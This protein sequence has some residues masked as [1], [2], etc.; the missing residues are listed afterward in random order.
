MGVSPLW[1]VFGKRVVPLNLNPEKENVVTTSEAILIIPIFNEEER[2]DL[3]YFSSLQCESAITILFVNDGS[4]DGTLRILKEYCSSNPR[5]K[6]ISLE[7]N[8]GKSAAVLH[9]MRVA[10]RMGVEIIGQT[11]ADQSVPVA[12]VIRGFYICRDNENAFL[13]SGARLR[14]AGSKHERDPARLWIGRIVATLV[15]LLT[16]NPLYDPQSP[17]KWWRL[18]TLGISAIE[19][20]VKTKWFGEAELW[21]RLQSL[22]ASSETSPPPPTRLVELDKARVVEFPLTH[23]VEVKGSK[24]SGVRSWIEVF[25]DLVKL[26]FVSFKSKTRNLRAPRIR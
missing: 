24:I 12:D 13:V 14:L 7:R 15:F 19:T 4:T 16:R 11:D 21:M 25:T 3:E 1:Y 5:V 6:V 2:L 20:N 18:N 23:W 26:A 9:G 10:S 22:Y 8:I 17:A